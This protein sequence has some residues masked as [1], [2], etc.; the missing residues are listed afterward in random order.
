[1]DSETDAEAIIEC[2]ETMDECMADDCSDDAIVDSSCML[3][4]DSN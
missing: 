2:V 4:L 1:M 3:G